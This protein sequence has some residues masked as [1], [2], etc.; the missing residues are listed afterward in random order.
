VTD[1]DSRIIGV[2]VDDLARY[3]R[4]GIAAA[5]AQYR[6]E[7][8]GAYLRTAALQILGT[9][10]LALIAGAAIVYGVRFLQGVVERRYRSRIQSVGVASF[11]IVR[12]GRPGAGCWRCCASSRSSFSG[13]RG[14]SF[15]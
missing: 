1:A 9:L 4:D 5:V 3:Y 12:G 7:R 14:W 13:S 11:E 2:S 6:H 15:R 8:S 10:A